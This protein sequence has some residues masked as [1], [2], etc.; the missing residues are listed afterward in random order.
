MLQ[1]DL[2]WR[3]TQFNLHDRA[4]N[5]LTLFLLSGCLPVGLAHFG[6]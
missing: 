4:K 2:E 5:P 6:Y 1:D 3:V